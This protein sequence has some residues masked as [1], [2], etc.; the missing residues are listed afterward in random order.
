MKIETSNNTL[1]IQLRYCFE[2]ENL[3]SMNAEVFNECERQFIKAIKS[4]EKYFEDTLQIKIKPREE[5]SLIDIF[6]ILINNPAIVA[7]FTTL[8]TIF[9]T[10]FFDFKFSSAKHKTDETSVK[11]DNLQAIKEQIKAGNLTEEDFDYIA[12]ND[13]EL[14][15]LKSNFFKKVKQDPDITKVEAKTIIDT[16]SQPIIIVVERQEFDYFIIPETTEKEED[17]QPAKI[18]IVSPI[19]V[20]GKKSPAWR[21]IFNDA[22]IDFRLTDKEF[23]QQVYGKVV[24]FSNGTFINCDLKTTITTNIETDETKMSREVTIVNNYGEDDNQIR[25]IT[26]RQKKSKKTATTQMPSLFDSLE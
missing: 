26:H 14:R 11:L 12:S 20:Q 19:L 2:D 25:K 9:A 3:H 15:K 8:I 10:K 5:G 6:T 1:T 22:P 23:L 21:G 16:N 4:T 7:T 17:T 24:K 13:K 18:Y